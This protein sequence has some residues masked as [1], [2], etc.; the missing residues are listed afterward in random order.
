MFLKH[1]SSE[2]NTDTLMSP[3]DKVTLAN[4]LKEVMTELKQAQALLSNKT[5][6]L[7]STTIGDEY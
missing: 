6:M 3:E 7:N 2:E 4:E 5:N 1:V